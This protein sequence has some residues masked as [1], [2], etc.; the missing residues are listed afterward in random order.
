MPPRSEETR[1][2]EQLL[3]P[4][5]SVMAGRLT[6]PGDERPAWLL[7]PLQ[8]TGVSDRHVIPACTADNKA[9]RHES[10]EA[11]SMACQTSAARSGSWGAAH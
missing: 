11:I 9:C 1:L 8:R 4:M 10:P 5:D 3:F 7:L 6:G 2:I